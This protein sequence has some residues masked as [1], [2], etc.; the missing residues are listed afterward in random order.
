LAGLNFWP[1]PAEIT[2]TSLASNLAIRLAASEDLLFFVLAE[3]TD[4]ELRLAP[5]EPL[6]GPEGAIFPR[7][8]WVRSER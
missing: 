5:V 4:G 3:A 1:L 6:R 2:A 8:E 7:W